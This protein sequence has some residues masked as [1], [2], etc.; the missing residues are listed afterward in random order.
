MP[1]DLSGYP[2]TDQCLKTYTKLEKFLLGE[3]DKP[4]TDQ[5]STEKTT[6][7]ILGGLPDHI[8]PGRPSHHNGQTSVHHAAWYSHPTPSTE[9]LELPATRHPA[10]AAVV[11]EI[12]VDVETRGLKSTNN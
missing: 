2:I 12:T 11:T 6:P 10:G 7:Q 5:Q 4:A 8:D 1:T 3:R 9:A